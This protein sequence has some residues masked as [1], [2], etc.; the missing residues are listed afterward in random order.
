MEKREGKLSVTVLAAKPK[1]DDDLFMT[2]DG[3]PN[4]VDLSLRFDE[5][6]P[7]SVLA[8]ASD[9]FERLALWKP[10]IVGVPLLWLVALVVAFAVPAAVLWAFASSVRALDD[11]DG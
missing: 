10:G 11:P 2:V 4:P 5:S 8:H 1:N 6:Q 3:Q 9:G 7:K